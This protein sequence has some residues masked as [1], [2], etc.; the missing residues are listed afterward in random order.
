MTRLHKILLVEDDADLYALLQFNLEREGFQFVGTQTGNGALEMIRREKPD[1]VLLDIM[2][3]GMGGL[4]I[5]SRMRSI[6]ELAS[7]PIIFLTARASA[8]DRVT[9]LET[10]A[11]DYVT[12]P[13][14]VREL[15]ARMRIRLRTRPSTEQELSACGIVMDR[16]GR[17]VFLHGNEVQLTATEFRLLE[18]LLRH[19]GVVLSREQLLKAV[20]KRQQTVTVRTV[21]VNILRL[22][23]KLSAGAEGLEYI[24]SVRGFG[25]SFEPKAVPE[26][27]PE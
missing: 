5:C 4:E 25:Y 11:D 8:D 18:H 10:G 15:I 7:L 17:R 23:N 9:G 14:S 16:A 1:L 3:P 12:K 24:R 6:P 2:L 22:R 20:W 27:A 26:P 13:F 21:D 19:P